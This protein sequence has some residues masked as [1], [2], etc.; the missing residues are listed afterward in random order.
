MAQH[1]DRLPQRRRTQI[2]LAQRAYRQR[3]ET[4][5]DELRHKVGELTG[6]LETVDRRLREF[7]ATAQHTSLSPQAVKELENLLQQ[8]AP[9]FAVASS[10][11]RVSDSPTGSD[12][13]RVADAETNEER[14]YTQASEPMYDPML[15]NPMVQNSMGPGVVG[16]PTGMVLEEVYPDDQ[17]HQRPSIPLPHHSRNPQ[18][19]PHHPPPPP[20]TTP[21]HHGNHAPQHQHQH[22]QHPQPHSRGQPY[23]PQRFYS[24]EQIS[25]AYQARQQV[26]MLDAGLYTHT[27]LS[28]SRTI[29]PIQ[30]LSNSERSFA[31][32]LQRICIEAGYE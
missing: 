1:T 8:L 5:I 25:Q 19:I 14:V 17:Y 23:P 6:A 31:R 9:V 32:R 28:Q 7:T 29:T 10:A 30:T 13:G 22:S 20:Q 11:S 15:E 2:R 24:Q 18:A 12:S 21:P 16:R 4:T 26:S 3:K 27:M